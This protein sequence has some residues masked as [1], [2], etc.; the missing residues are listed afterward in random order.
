MSI[1]SIYMFFT[2][3]CAGCCLH[4]ICSEPIDEDYRGFSR[5]AYWMHRIECLDRTREHTEDLD[6]D[7]DTDTDTPRHNGL[8]VANVVSNKTTTQAIIMNR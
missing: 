5:A 2:G 4:Y 1:S 3:L 8:P 6:L 7:T